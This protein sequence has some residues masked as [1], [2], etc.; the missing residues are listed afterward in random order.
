MKQQ[1]LIIGG[2]TSFDNYDDYISYLKKDREISIDKIKIRKTWK[3]TMDVK[4]GEDFEVFLP[5]MPNTLNARYFEWKIWFE[6]VLTL[7]GDDLIFIGHSLGGIFLAKYL[8]ENIIDK[9][10]KTVI[11]VAA[12]FNDTDSV[13]SL[14]D[15]KL[16]DSF[17]N[18]SKQCENIYLIQSKDDP[19]VPFEQ[20]EKYKKELPSAK[21][22]AFEDR[23]HFSQET[24]PEIIELIKQI[25]K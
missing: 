6:R 17:S 25:A 19:V 1:I 14:V 4:L 21:I 22:M 7:L 3:N 11:L 20:V 12:P 5:E 18:L 15:F 16:P 8:S 2:G 9:K 24:F 13:E 10:I 23:G